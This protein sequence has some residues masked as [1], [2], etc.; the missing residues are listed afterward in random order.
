MCVELASKHNL[1]NRIP[2]VRK[3]QF[4]EVLLVLKVLKVGSILP[5]MQLLLRSKTGT[6][7]KDSGKGEFKVLF[8]LAASGNDNK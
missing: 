6:G 3:I 2:N 7:A 8:M 4:D 5:S 1:T